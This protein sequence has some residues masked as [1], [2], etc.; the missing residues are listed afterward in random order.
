LQLTLSL[1]TNP[2]LPT[3]PPLPS[4]PQI[5]GGINVGDLLAAIDGVDVR[6]M[7]VEQVG[8]DAVFLQSNIDAVGREEEGRACLTSPQPASTTSMPLH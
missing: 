8:G 7:S 5:Q 2:S 6:G 3:P 1:A 4:R